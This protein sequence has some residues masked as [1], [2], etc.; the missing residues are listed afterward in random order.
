MIFN[1]NLSI[2]H[3]YLCADGYVIKNPKT[4]KQKYYYIGFRNMNNVLLED[5]EKNFFEYFKVKSRRCK[6]GRSVVQNKALYYELTKEFSYYSREWQIPN[7]SDDNLR[8]WLRAF[9]DC[10]GWVIVR[11]AKDRHIGLDS[12]NHKGLRDIKLVLKK[13]KIESKLRQ[14]KNRDTLRLLIYGRD[15]LIRFQKQINFLHPNKK[16]KLQEA[17]D[18]YV[19]YNWDFSD[20]RLLL[21]RLLRNKSGK[22]IRFNSIIKNNVIK[23]SEYLKELGIESKIYFNQNKHSKYWELCVQKKDSVKKLL[24]LK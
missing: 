6:D 9:F 21:Q 13:F 3:A 2:I 12:I 4:Q 11:K 22:R 1:K 5:F 24:K 7:L 16:T 8:Y 18:S 23:L 15:N 19:D 17:I 14:S 10:E 20:K